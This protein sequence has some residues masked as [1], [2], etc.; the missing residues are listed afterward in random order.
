MRTRLATAVVA[1]GLLVAACGGDTNTP[2][3]TAGVGGA[4]V[5]AAPDADADDDGPAATRL[6]DFQASSVEG[7]TIDV[8]A[9]SGSDLVIWFWAP[10]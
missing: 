3:D 2:A 1:A 10:W 8:G 7:S 9:R 5:Q 6:L 4:G